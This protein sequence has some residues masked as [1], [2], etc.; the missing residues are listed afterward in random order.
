MAD[1]TPP[2]IEDR[3][4]TL[5]RQIAEILRRDRPAKDW[6]RVVG[7]FAD[8]EFSRRVDEAGR[9]IRERERSEAGA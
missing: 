5:E 6:R 1:A 9:A 2:T 8:D 4:S 3:L 7:M